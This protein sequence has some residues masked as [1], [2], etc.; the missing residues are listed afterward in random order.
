ME[1]RH[2]RDTGQV[3]LVYVSWQNDRTYVKEIELP[4]QFIDTLRS[5]ADL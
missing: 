1:L 4:Y 3:H 5:A 2:D